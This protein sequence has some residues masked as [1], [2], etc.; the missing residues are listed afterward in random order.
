[1][2]TG[3]SKSLGHILTLNMS[4]TIKEIT[5]HLI[6]SKGLQS[7]VFHKMF[8]DVQCEHRKSHATLQADSQIPAKM[9]SSIVLSM[10]A[11]WNNFCYSAL[12]SATSFGT[13]GGAH[14]SVLS[15]NP[16]KEVARCDIWRPRISGQENAII[17]CR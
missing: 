14:R 5:M 12:S 2:Y 10:I 17:K 16:Q 15:R 4:K 11:N 13:G 9:R 3:C 1:M 6:Y 8:K 7:Q